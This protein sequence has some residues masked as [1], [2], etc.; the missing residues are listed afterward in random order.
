MASL[1]EELVARGV[2]KDKLDLA[3]RLQSHLAQ[4]EGRQLSLEQ[5]LREQR[6]VDSDL[7]DEVVQKAFGRSATVRVDIPIAVRKRLRVQVLGGVENGL[8]KV[9]SVAQL[10]EADREYLVKLVRER[11]ITECY[12]V[13]ET[14]GNAA[15][16]LESINSESVDATRLSNSLGALNADPINAD[17]SLPDLVQEIVHEAVELGASDI[18]VNQAQSEFENSVAYR[19][20]GVR[21]VRHLLTEQ[22]AKSV[23]GVL[24]QMSGMDSAN[25][26]N[27]QDGRMSASYQGR[28]IDVRVAVMPLYGGEGESATLR[29]LD[30]YNLKPL[31]NLFKEHPEVLKRLQALT[32]LSSKKEGLVFITGA[33]GSGKSTT[34]YSVISS[35]DREHLCIRSVE[36]PIEQHIPGVHQVQVNEAAGMTFPAALKS[37]L[38][39]D[40]DVIVVGE[41]RDEETL[42]LLVKAD[43]T[44]HLVMST[45]H[46]HSVP[47]TFDRVRTLL[48]SFDKE[49]GMLTV[50]NTL[51][52]VMNQRL[53][54]RLCAC[55]KP[56]VAGNHPDPKLAEFARQQGFDQLVVGVKTGC[57]SCNHTG[58]TR[59][60][61]QVPE[62][63]FIPEN[64]ELRSEIFRL[65][66]NNHTTEITKLPG[67]FYYSRHDAVRTLLETRLMDLSRANELLGNKQA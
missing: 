12:A 60:R 65:W 38:R 34:L 48:P 28:N 4:Y 52:L 58:F 3:L 40:P 22:A 27:P 25:R 56:V 64:E 11:G 19:I 44:G 49:A 23:M 14:I 59:Q 2:D 24:K 53:E 1:T 18:H 15:D 37:F 41:T 35:M 7:L 6:L 46:T 31:S 20:G 50:S 55:A 17:V 45:L 62:A 47:G 21:N 9:S 10:R 36:D 51:K 43:E 63:L 29:I 57:P 39:Q 54:K 32:K 8:L 42:Q 33:T 30:P 61:V 26:H 67:V 5:I 13:Q 66:R 16:I